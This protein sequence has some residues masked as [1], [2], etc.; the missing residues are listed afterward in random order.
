MK[1]TCS[2]SDLLK[3]VNIVSKAVTTRTTMAILECILI[4][5]DSNEIKLT[6][7]DMELGIETIVE[8]TVLE[9]G[10]IALDAKLFSEIVRKLPDDS[11]ITIVTDEKYK[12]KI[13]YNGNEEKGLDIVGKPG[14]DFPYIPVITRNEP[15][16]ISQLTFKDIVRQTIFSLSNDPKDNVMTGELFEIK[17]NVLKMVALDRHRVAI[18]NVE[19]SNPAPDLSVVIPGKS[20]NEVTKILDGGIDDMINVY[21]TEHHII[22]EFNR[23]TVVSRLIDKQ[24]INIDKMI[25]VDFGTNIKVNKKLLTNALDRSLIFVTEQ[26]KKPIVINFSGNNMNISISSFKGNMDEDIDI[27]KDGEDMVIGVDPKYILDAVKVIDDEEINIHMMNIK[28]SPCYIK[29]NDGTSIYMV[30][31]VNR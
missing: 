16:V 8:G 14:D 18:A 30:M 7:N 19:L 28:S 17:N 22:F 9:R 26:D 1:I 10:I 4:N 12:T 6:A 13:I 31:P 2:K 15:V 20:L 5:A 27:V 21:I 11:D 23:T 29:N 24:F 3:G 25:N